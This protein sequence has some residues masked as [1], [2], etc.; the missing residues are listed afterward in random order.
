M[1]EPKVPSNLVSIVALTTESDGVQT[2]WPRGTIP[3]I[4]KAENPL[5]AAGRN[6]ARDASR[7]C[8][9]ACERP[10]IPQENLGG[11]GYLGSHA[12]EC[13]NA[14]IGYLTYRTA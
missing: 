12:K 3:P 9:W 4:H 10:G 5:D 14:I 2:P 6:G 11:D 13:S 1:F 8:T 7:I